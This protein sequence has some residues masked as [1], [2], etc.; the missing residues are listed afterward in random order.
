MHT[1]YHF[2][3]AVIILC[4]TISRALADDPAAIEVSVTANRLER[5][6]SKTASSVSIITADEIA[7]R[8]IS[9]VAAALKDVVGIDVVESGGAGGN[10]AV[11]LRG[12]NSEHTLVLIDGIEANDPISPSRAFNFANLSVDNVERIEV[13]RGPQS[14]LYGSDAI[15]G[16]INIITKKGD[17][18]PSLQAS[19]EAGSYG[20][21]LQRL[22][23]SGSGGALNYSAAY[24]RQDTNGFSAASGGK[25]KDGYSANV[26]S[27]RVGAA[28]SELIDIGGFFRFTGANS[29]LDN[30]AGAS[31]DDPNRTLDNRQL[32]SR[33]EINTKFLAGAITQQIFINYSKQRFDDDND[34][35]IDHPIDL[36]RSNYDGRSLKVGIQNNIKPVEQF[37]LTLGAEFEREQG[38]SNFFSNSSFGEFESELPKERART[39]SVF[40]QTL[41]EVTDSI[42]GAAGLRVDEHDRFG[43]KVT[44]RAGPVVEAADTKLSGTVGSAFKAPSLSQLYSQFGDPNLNPEEALGFDIGI[45]QKVN[46]DKFSL[47]TTYFHSMIDQLISFNSET[48]K[49]ENIGRARLQGFENFARLNICESTSLRF[50]Y[51]LTE[52]QDRDLDQALLRR[53]RHKIGAS[54]TSQAFSK[55][56]I[57]LGVHYVGARSDTDFSTFPAT[58]VTLGGYV[59][60]DLAARYAIAGNV[61][62]FARAENIFDRDY[63][64]VLGY[65][66]AG[67]AAYGGVEVKFN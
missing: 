50:N 60:A 20:R 43:T 67:A 38:S 53:A 62:L 64:S 11:F 10:V 55:L 42:S 27:S 18:Q 41:T 21:F 32:F 35:D 66:T 40:V 15:A 29:E 19:S 51:T 22:A 4:I 61:D 28:V 31:G 58:R 33:A 49:S 34:P 54:V 13:V 39:R 47:G 26:F 8:Q 24:A 9:S 56:K 3:S 44:W 65:G 48:F 59:L 25:E 52:A 2:L 14:V 23:T 16:V 12:A 5:E 7:A 1:N 37:T 45:E 6:R 57:D 46:K 30:D 36:Q 63:Q 17:N